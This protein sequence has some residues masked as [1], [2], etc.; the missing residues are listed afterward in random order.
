[1][2]MQVKLLRVLQDKVVERIGGGKPRQI[3][4][5]IISATNQDLEG[6]I[7]K[8]TFRLDLFYRLNVVTISLP[9]LR[10]IADDIP[11]LFE[12]MLVELANKQRVPLK[13]VEEEALEALKAYAW[14]GNVRELRN[15]AEQVMF[16][17]D[18]EQV[19]VGD[20]PPKVRSG[21]AP[22]ALAGSNNRLL[23]QSVESAERQAIEQALRQAGQNKA[24]ASKLL[25][26][27]RTGLYQKMRR[28]GML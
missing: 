23:K 19:E 12:T 6:I 15:V 28:Y 18:G 5:R 22:M 11:L 7:R 2:R 3:N 16:A 17:A 9:A 20:L 27:H 26:I 1:L 24:K 25:G 8:G 10:I 13:K 14:P 21:I 4:F